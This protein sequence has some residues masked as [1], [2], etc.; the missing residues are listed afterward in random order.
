MC[1]NISK[2]ISSVEANLEITCSAPFQ[3]TALPLEP[4]IFQTD[5]TVQAMMN[6][7]RS[8]KSVIQDGLESHSTAPQM[9]QKIVKKKLGGL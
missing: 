3:T 4:L 7:R 2:P 8:L 1:R 6:V 5:P 9:M